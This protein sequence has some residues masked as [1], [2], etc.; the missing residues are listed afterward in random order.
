M[1]SLAVDQH[2]HLVRVEPAQHEGRRMVGAVVPG[3]PGRVEP[4]NELHQRLAELGKATAFQLRSGDHINRHF[5][6]E[7]VARAG[8]G[9]HFGFGRCFNAQQFAQRFLVVVVGLLQRL[10]LPKGRHGHKGSGDGQGN[11]FHGAT[12]FTTVASESKG[13]P[14]RMFDLTAAAWLI[15][16]RVCCCKKSSWMMPPRSANPVAVLTVRIEFLAP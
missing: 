11:G 16:I 10:F 4:G 5:G 1:Q 12:P 2:Q 7:G 13:A 3:R 8:S 14:M 15:L 6:L 9:A